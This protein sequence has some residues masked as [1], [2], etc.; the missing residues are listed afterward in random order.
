MIVVV[1]HLSSSKDICTSMMEHRWAAAKGLVGEPKGW[2]F[3]AEALG[4]L[5]LLK[6]QTNPTNPNQLEVGLTKHDVHTL[7]INL[8]I[9]IDY[10]S[11]MVS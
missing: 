8:C 3:R 1:V 5:K 6:L 11:P 10:R 7:I 2:S 4:Q 9:G